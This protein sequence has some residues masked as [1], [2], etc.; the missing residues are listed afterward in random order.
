MNQHEKL[1]GNPLILIAD[2]DSA[3]RS[4]MCEVLEHAGFDTIEASDGEA[5]IQSYECTGPDLILL[6]VDMPH[7]DGFSVC[8]KI[9]EKE[10]KRNTPICIVSGLDD[11]KSIQRAYEVGATDF[12]SKPIAWPIL[13]HRV[14]YILRSSDTFNEMNGLIS[15]L[16]DTIYVLNKDGQSHGHPIG[17]G[18]GGRATSL[19]G[20]NLS[21][22]DMFP[23]EGDDQLREYVKRTLATSEPQVLE[24]AN[25]DESIH[26]ETRFIARDEQSVLAIVRDVTERKNSESQIYD[27]AFFD[28]LTGL[29]NRQ[30]FAKA[31]DQTIRT[32]HRNQS[33]FAI[34]F[35]DL[36]RFKRINDTLGHSIGDD[37]LKSVSKRLEECTRSTDRLLHVNPGCLEDA[38]LARLGG[39]EFIAILPEVECEESASAIA[40][41]ILAS[42]SQPFSC[43]GYQFVVTPSIGI[44]MYPQDGE[45]QEELLMNA[46]S[47]MYKAKAAGRNNFQFYS[48]TMKVRSLFRLDLENELRQAIKEQQFELYYQPKIDLSTWEIVGVEAL[49]RWNHAE[50]GWISPADFIPVA[51]ESGLIVSL[52]TWVIRTA[53]QQLRQW[54]NTPFGHL[55]LSINVSPQQIYSDDLGA[56]V[57]NA[58]TDSGARADRLEL[59]ITEGL[60]MRD[61]EATVESL[62]YL[63]SLGLSLSIDDFGTGYSSL[64]YLKRF[65]IDILKI[66]RSFVQDL[67]RD[68]DDA[69]I[70][71]AIIAM[72][73]QLDLKVIAEG[74]ELEEQLTFLKRHQCDQ[75]QGY[76][77]SK[78]LT[79]SDFESLVQTHSG[80]DQETAKQSV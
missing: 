29:P 54:Q 55:T 50:R 76:I 71:A 41:R 64:S 73:R 43:D 52:G 58:L 10:S 6:D 51:E 46:D 12:I 57:C 14:R 9:R 11:D 35:I 75:I 49:L 13:C 23:Q 16:P 33:K 18:H 70:C 8:E 20:H 25:T 31:V 7:L 24:H 1:Q 37:L 53:C 47:A 2:S 67:H 27:L 59:E 77:F 72:A 28:K 69:A 22:E 60:L 32:A 26:F 5:A 38:R 63:K 66:D 40:S 3:T 48:G 17:A 39:D 68:S 44:A 34:L 42:L 62:T 79:V 74:V 21:F 30:H 4:M 45:N 80:C 36:D 56:A 15:A 19:P 61:V 78:P 65:P